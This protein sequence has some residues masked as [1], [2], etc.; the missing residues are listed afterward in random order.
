MNDDSNLAFSHLNDLR[1]KRTCIIGFERIF[2]QNQQEIEGDEHPPAEHYEN[3]KAAIE[4]QNEKHLYKALKGFSKYLY[5]NG[6]DDPGEFDY[7]DM[8]SVFSQISQIR[9]EDERILQMTFYIVSL[10]QSKGPEYVKA[11][12]SEDV[13]DL[14]MPHI[15]M[16][17]RVMNS[18]VLYHALV[19]LTNYCG[20]SMEARD[21]IMPHIPLSIIPN[22][23]CH[24]DVNV[25]EAALD[26]CFQYIRYPID[27]SETKELYHIAA[28]SLNTLF[29]NLYSTAV[30]IIV[31]IMRL[32]PESVKA[33]LEQTIR[34]NITPN[35]NMFYLGECTKLIDSNQIPI[36]YLINTI[37]KNEEI[38]EYIL[39]CLLFIS[40]SYEYDTPIEKLR[41]KA[42]FHA[43]QCK[44]YPDIQVQAMKTIIKIIHHF[45]ETINEMIK[46]GILTELSFA[47]DESKF[48]MKIILGMY[49]C[50]LIKDCGTSL[51][52]KIVIA[53]AVN[54]F[55]DFLEFD[56]D[57][58]SICT[59][60]CLE[61]VFDYASNTKNF[62]KI[63]TRFKNN[64]G[65]EM[66]CNIIEETE[67]EELRS[68]AQHFFEAHLNDV[69]PDNVSDDE[70]KLLEVD[71]NLTRIDKFSDDENDT[72]ENNNNDQD[73]NHW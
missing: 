66:I 38:E 34:N 73:D 71:G 30:W 31:F 50:Q 63:Y 47:I 43:L 37:L 62:A 69:N 49:T 17:D 19:C 27:A 61:L 58:L 11:F 54:L 60:E 25:K 22:F 29:T 8:F 10:L 59:I 56:D 28:D 41:Y 44:N 72:D 24:H 5:E 51:I 15:D 35:V 26:L 3:I 42:L 21:L 46:K 9:F 32:F 1:N 45:P 16:N 39:P 48:A 36:S 12:L 52:H 18:P 4:E 23:L 68:I 2:E 57:Q 70:D 64:D 20:E 14:C 13:L 65:Y 67:N 6:F 33:I 7:Y 40:Y 55:T 53:V